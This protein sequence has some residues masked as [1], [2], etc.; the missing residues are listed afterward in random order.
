MTSRW[1]CLAIALG[2]A[3]LWAQ[4][5]NGQIVGQVRDER[6][7]PVAGARVDIHAVPVGKTLPKPF[8]ASATTKADGTYLIAV[9]SGTFQVCANLRGSQLLDSCTWTTAPAR[10]I[11]AG[12][13]RLELAPIVLKRGHLL[14]VRLDDA[15]GVLAQEERKRGGARL[16]VGISTRYGMFRP[17]ASRRLPTGRIHEV[18]VPRDTPLEVSLHGRGFALADEKG[19]AVDVR[20]G[21]Q[22]S[23]KLEGDR[24]RK[25][26]VFRINGVQDDGGKK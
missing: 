15:R 14:T 6:L 13:Q 19:A 18:L 8:Q 21:H 26:L 4:A 10:A 3:L 7:R 12:G 20:R 16:L 22:V 24:S 23:L 1:A 2:G 17:M 25:Q 5:P 11:V 9:P